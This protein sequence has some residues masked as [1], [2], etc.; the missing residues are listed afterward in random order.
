MRHRFGLDRNSPVTHSRS[1]MP[2]NAHKSRLKFCVRLRSEE[3]QSERVSIGISI[4]RRKCC[5]TW[6]NARP[7]HLRGEKSFR[8]ARR[9]GRSG[10]S[11]RSFKNDRGQLVQD[12]ERYTLARERS[13]LRHRRNSTSR[14]AT[15]QLRSCPEK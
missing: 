9:K 6:S 3:Q 4:F 11:E 15:W 13:A 5:S 8:S 7:S 10:R 12:R 1:V 2:K 14:D